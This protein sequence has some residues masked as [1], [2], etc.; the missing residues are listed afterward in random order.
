M[1]PKIKLK[2]PDDIGMGWPDDLSGKTVEVE[3]E[4]IKNTKG[5]TWYFMAGMTAEIVKDEPPKPRVVVTSLRDLMG[6][7]VAEIKFK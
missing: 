4:A 6:Q 2:F 7:D 1:K 3:I 5:E